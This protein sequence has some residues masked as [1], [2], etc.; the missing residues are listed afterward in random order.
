[1]IVRL[2]WGSGIPTET[3]RY[4]GKR[5]MI[6]SSQ[7]VAPWHLD[8]RGM[9]RMEHALVTALISAMAITA[10]LVVGN[11]AWSAGNVDFSAGSCGS[12][13]GSSQREAAFDM[14]ILGRRPKTSIGE[15]PITPNRRIQV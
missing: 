7:L 6:S 15:R 8:N 5:P 2:A 4:E 11:V 3:E 12:H 1:M 9:T 10:I 14:S 13:Y